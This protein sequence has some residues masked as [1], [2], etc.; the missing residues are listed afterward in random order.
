LRR[1]H[2]RL[3]VDAVDR[4][5]LR[6]RRRRSADRRPLHDGPTRGRGRAGAA[7]R[8]TLRP[9]PL[10]DVPGADRDA[11]RP[12]KAGARRRGDHDGARRNGGALRRRWLGATG[13]RVPEIA[14]EGELELPADV[15]WLEQATPEEV[16]A[17]HESVRPVAA[18]AADA[19]GVKAALAHPEVA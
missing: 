18:H 4:A 17:A 19:E 8:Q 11:G 1:R 5:D 15:L 16:R 14:V 7:R 13:K 2:E 10:R 6:A 9:L 3:R 12:T